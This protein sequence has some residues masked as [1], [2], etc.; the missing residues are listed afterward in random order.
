MLILFFFFFFFISKIRKIF[1]T[2]ICA[3]RL[4]NIVMFFPMKTLS[5]LNLNVNSSLELFNIAFNK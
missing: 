2:E 4:F 1:K 5:S 3:E